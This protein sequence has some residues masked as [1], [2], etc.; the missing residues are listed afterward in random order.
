MVGRLL[1]EN[2]TL[3]LLVSD[4]DIG[5]SSRC[6]PFLAEIAALSEKEKARG[7]VTAAGK[8]TPPGIGEGE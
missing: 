8:G 3:P 5:A 1:I 6:S 7:T 4:W 2:L